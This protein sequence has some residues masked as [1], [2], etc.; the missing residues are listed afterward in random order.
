VPDAGR[1]G[2]TRESGN[3]AAAAFDRNG[4][5]SADEVVDFGQDSAAQPPNWHNIAKW[6]PSLN[7]GQTRRQA[8]Q[9]PQLQKQN[10]SPM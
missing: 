9:I 6:P 4:R 1:G 8:P 7:L 10:S 5:S 2:V 3:W